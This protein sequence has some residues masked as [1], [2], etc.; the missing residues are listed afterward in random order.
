M[1]YIPNL[2]ISISGR[3]PLRRSLLL[4][5]LKSV[6][7]TLFDP[8]QENSPSI[9][10]LAGNDANPHMVTACRLR[11]G[12]RLS[13]ASNLSTTRVHVSSLVDSEMHTT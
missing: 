7:L 12:Y 1:N 5:L 11:C 3:P 8:F 10:I 13:S 6:P 2:P 4:N 9:I